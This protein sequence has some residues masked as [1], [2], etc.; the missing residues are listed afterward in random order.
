MKNNGKMWEV[1]KRSLCW[2]VIKAWGFAGGLMTN[3][4]IVRGMEE[5][6]LGLKSF[7]T[8]LTSFGEDLG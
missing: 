2:W 7:N 4:D 8:F 1:W 3:G 5:G 6:K